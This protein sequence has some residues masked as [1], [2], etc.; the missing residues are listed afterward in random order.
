MNDCSSAR[1]G[2]GKAIG[3]MM[4][5]E[6][7]VTDPVN[8]EI[9]KLKASHERLH[10]LYQVSNV[11]H[12]TLDS[13]E[14]LQLIVDREAVDRQQVGRLWPALARLDRLERVSLALLDL[15]ANQLRRVA[16]VDARK[17]RLGRLGH[18]Y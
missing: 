4:L 3:E 11:I 10:L 9:L 2:R 8:T 12:S 6:H 17:V 13:Q 14:A 15:L 16:Q 7:K 5:T 18:L 1:G